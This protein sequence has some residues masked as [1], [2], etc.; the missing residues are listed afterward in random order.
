[1]NQNTVLSVE[2]IAEKYDEENGFNDYFS[3]QMELKTLSASFDYRQIMKLRNHL[4]QSPSIKCI[5]ECA[6]EKEMTV[7]FEVKEPLPLLDILSNIPSVDRLIAQ[8]D[9]VNLILKNHSKD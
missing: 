3:G 1:L 7:L 6:S 5:T 9:G 8:D 2:L 4:L